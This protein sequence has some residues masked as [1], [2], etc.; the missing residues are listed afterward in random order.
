MNARQLQMIENAP[1]DLNEAQLKE[2]GRVFGGLAK[3]P[4]PTQAI[5]TE[6]IKPFESVKGLWIYKP[7]SQDRYQF[8]N[9]W[10]VIFQ[11]TEDAIVVHAATTRSDATYK[12]WVNYKIF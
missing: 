10:R 6:T 8:E 11:V 4:N 5:G 2:V 3:R 9:N 1:C 12:N 7:S